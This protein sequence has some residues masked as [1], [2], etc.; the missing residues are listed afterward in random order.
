M[1]TIADDCV[2][3]TR[4]SLFQDDLEYFKKLIKE[5]GAIPASAFEKAIQFKLDK[6]ARA[7]FPECQPGRMRQP[8]NLTLEN[9]NH[10]DIYLSTLSFAITDR[11]LLVMERVG[12]KVRAR[13]RVTST[14]EP[15]LNQI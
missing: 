10:R 11:G 14:Y 4:C 9:P 2:S 1:L 8:Q 15:N 13:G 7:L 12:E 3:L 5:K 6:C